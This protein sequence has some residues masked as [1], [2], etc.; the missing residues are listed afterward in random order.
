MALPVTLSGGSSLHTHAHTHTRTHTHVHTHT[1]TLTHTYTHTRT[2]TH[3]HTHVHAHTSTH[4]SSVTWSHLL[5]QKQCLLPHDSVLFLKERVSVWGCVC[6]YVCVCTCVCVR[7]CVCVCECTCVRVRVCECVC[8]CVYV[9]VCT[10]VCV[11]VYVYGAALTE[12]HWQS[13]GHLQ[14]VSSCCGHCMMVSIEPL[15]CYCFP[16]QI[17][18][19]LVEWDSPLEPVTLSPSHSLTHSNDLL[20]LF[21]SSTAS[22]TLSVHPSSST[23]STSSGTSG[24]SSSTLTNYQHSWLNVVRLINTCLA[25][26]CIMFTV[27]ENFRMLAAAEILPS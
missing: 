19:L 27:M 18:W 15:V 1:H 13:H 8:V 21:Y 20:G 7:V 3:T 12:G 2:L 23:A 10:C 17:G 25:S 6:V 26:V 16:L 9:C 11:C 22:L 5:F 24:H 14:V 4:C